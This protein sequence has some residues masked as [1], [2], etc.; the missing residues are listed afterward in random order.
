MVER[1]EEQLETALARERRQAHERLRSSCTEMTAH[2][3]ELRQELVEQ[4]RAL[5][6]TAESLDARRERLQRDV[7]A[8]MSDL[9]TQIVELSG[10]LAKRMQAKLTAMIKEFN[11]QLETDI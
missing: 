11:D 8:H 7:I 2:L 1:V 5:E 3:N 9:E 4:R 10:A 6:Q